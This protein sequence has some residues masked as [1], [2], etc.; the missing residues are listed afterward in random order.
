MVHA[1]DFEGKYSITASE[2]DV[3]VFSFVGF[4]SQRITV[5][6]SDVINISIQDDSSELQEVIVTAYLLVFLYNP[7]NR[8][9]SVGHKG[10]HCIDQLK[11]LVVRKICWS[12]GCLLNFFMI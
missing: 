6:A 5:G 9:K 1:T 12:N 8:Q 2:G 7:P 11:A 10:I 3:L 4:I